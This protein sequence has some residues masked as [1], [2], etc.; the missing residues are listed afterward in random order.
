MEP[1]LFMTAER[2]GYSGTLERGAGLDRG[3]CYSTLE[4]RRFTIENERGEEM[5]RN[6]INRNASYDMTLNIPG[7]ES[8][9]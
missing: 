5:R 4:R 7:E 8:T 3:G 6:G 2:A 9:I 1:G